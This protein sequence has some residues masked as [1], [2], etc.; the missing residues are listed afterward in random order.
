MAAARVPPPEKE[1]KT[2]AWLS[3][4]LRGSL[5]EVRPL[6]GMLYNG[7]QAQINRTIA[8]ITIFEKVCFFHVG[9]T[10]RIS[11]I[12]GWLRCRVAKIDLLYFRTGKVNRDL[13][14]ILSKG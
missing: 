8:R 6:P 4:R 9:I 13:D 3:S 11:T 2:N 5:G 7:A 14:V 1:T 12:I 10:T